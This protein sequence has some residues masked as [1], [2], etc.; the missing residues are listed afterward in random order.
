MKFREKDRGARAVKRDGAPSVS[1][2]F[3]SIIN[4]HSTRDT[5]G[6]A[7]FPSTAWKRQRFGEPWYPGETLSISIGQGYVTT[8]PLQMAVLTA[9]I[10]VVEG[11]AHGLA[12]ERPLEEPA[13]RHSEDHH[14]S[15]Q[16]GR[17]ATAGKAMQATWDPVRLPYHTKRT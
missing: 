12:G 4:W 14:E 3:L 5:E 10:D 9:K 6:V 1:A 8:T 17:P 7:R 13:H 16:Q 11:R 2:P 15:D